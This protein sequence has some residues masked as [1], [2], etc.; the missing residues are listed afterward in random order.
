M[1]GNESIFVSPKE[2]CRIIGLSR[3][4]VDRLRRRGQFVDSF[5][6]TGAPNGRS[7]LSVASSSNVATSAGDGRFDH[8]QTTPNRSVTPPGPTVQRW[9]KPG[10]FY[11]PLVLTLE[12]RVLPEF[13]L[14]M[15]AGMPPFYRWHERAG[16]NAVSET[17]L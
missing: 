9:D 11:M 4:Q 5:E 13:R 8:R 7:A 2:A 1:D 16:R 10:D 14:R 3:A 12:S 15:R 17:D 6:L